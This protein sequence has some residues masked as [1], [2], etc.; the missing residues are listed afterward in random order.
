MGSL[1]DYSAQLLCSFYYLDRYY[2]D[3]DDDYDDNDSPHWNQ[4][5]SHHK[6]LFHDPQ[7]ETPKRDRL[8][9]TTI[10]GNYPFYITTK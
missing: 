10:D 9:P 7:A 6:V 2:L 1:L 8:R 5:R 3:N 4:N